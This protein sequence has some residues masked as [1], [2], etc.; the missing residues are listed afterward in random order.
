MNTADILRIR[1]RAQLIDDGHAKSVR[2]VVSRLLAMQAQDYA[3]ATWAIGLRLPGSTLVDVERAIAERAIVRTWPM[4]GTLHFVATEDVRWLLPLLTPRVVARFRAR[5]EELGL[6]SGAFARARELFSA[7]LAGG[8]SLT[9][10]EAMALLATGGVATE[11]QRGYH[12][13]VQ[14]A[15]EG[16]LVQGPMRDKQQTFVLL[17]EW[18]PPTD[19]DAAALARPREEALAALA[20]RYFAGHGPATVDDLA[21]WAGLPK[22]EAAAATAAIAGELESAEYDGARYW[23]APEVASATSRTRRRTPSVHLLPGFDEYMLGYTGRSHQLGEH[24]EAYG[25]KVAAN[26]MLAPTI[27]VDGRAVGIW[28]RTLKARTVGFTT[29]GFEPLG[30]AERKAIAAEQDRYAAFVGRKRESM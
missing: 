16:L 6:D 5:H 7:A 15:H 13:L 26:G 18:I 29:T 30:A 4:R 9:R 22:R 24:L 12:V 20:A 3:G 14:L 1:L 25:S 10:P 23:F 21:R 2:E 27:V 19:A 8:G 28:K 11:G 17:D